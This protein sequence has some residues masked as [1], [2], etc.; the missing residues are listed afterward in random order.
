MQVLVDDR[1]PLEGPYRH[2]FAD[3]EVRVTR[4]RLS[5]GDYLF[6]ERLLFERKTARDFGQSLIDGRLFS[7]AIRLR[8]SGS[9]SVMV[10]E[11][12]ETDWQK[13][14]ISREAQ[15]GA[16]ITLAIIIGLPLLH[17][18]HA[19]ETARLMFQAARQADRVIQGGIYRPGYRPK[20]KRKRQLFILQGLP[21]IGPQRAEQ[22]LDALGSIEE[23]VKA[24]AHTLASVK[25]IGRTTAQE[26]RNVIKDTQASY[27]IRSAQKF[28]STYA[29]IT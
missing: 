27:C 6:D 25:G 24:D 2:L 7:Q 28:C 4:K 12:R 18:V 9:P 11:G 22:L 8:Q 3:P 13:T 5:V 14:G 29:G 23:I 20:G 15:Q 1:E 16:L 19:A 10:L 21:G 26:I 17:S